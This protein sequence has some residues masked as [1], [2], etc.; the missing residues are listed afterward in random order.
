MLGDSTTGTRERDAGSGLVPAAITDVGCEREIN[1]DRYAVIDCPLGKIWVVC[2][3]MGGSLG[4]ELAAQLAIDTIRRGLES[5]EFDTPQ[6][7]LTFAVEEANRVIVLRRQ[8][9]QFSSMGTTIVAAMLSGSQVVIAHA[10]DSR[11]YL[12]RDGSIEQLTVDHTY[13][14]DLVERGAISEDEALSHPQAHVLTRCLGADP[15]LKLDSLEFWNWKVGKGESKD[16][17]ILVS[18]G[19]YSLVDDQEIAKSVC[20]RSAQE[21]CVE[22]VELAK[23]RGGFD[24]I[25]VSILP[26]A[27]QL[28]GEEPPAA[29]KAGP[30][31]QKR[32]KKVEKI[33]KPNPFEGFTLG[34]RLV[35]MLLLFLLG[36]ISTSLVLALMT[37][38]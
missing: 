29:K 10:G 4:G 35:F 33:E 11:A 17:L 26:L 13:V 31:L 9:P 25:T 32:K 34:K 23:A 27:G 1:E 15:R 24:N 37:F 36:L 30:K 18:D 16:I 3:G 19:L 28:R 38:S 21:S 22:L 6:E 14:Q 8:N 5:K 20:S 12:V 7:A 2:D